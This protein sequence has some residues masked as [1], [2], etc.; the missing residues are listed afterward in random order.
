MGTTPA[1]PTPPTPTP[2][3]SLPVPY[4]SN[5]PRAGQLGPPT[6]TCEGTEGAAAGTAGAVAAPPPHTR[7]DFRLPSLQGEWGEKEG[8]E[9]GGEGGGGW[10]NASEWT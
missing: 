9:K 7:T 6:V 5:R 4:G 3:H 2:A 10:M 1:H 8:T